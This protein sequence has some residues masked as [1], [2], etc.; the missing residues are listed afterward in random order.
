M[1]QHQIANDPSQALDINIVGQT[2]HIFAYRIWVKEPGAADWTEIA[3][4]DTADSVPDHHLTGPHPDGTLISIAYAVGGK[5]K[6]NF[7][8]LSTFSQGGAMVTGGAV[9]E[10][11][12]T[13]ASG[14][15]AR[16]SR[17][18]LA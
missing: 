8:V 2:P 11:G 1:A 13:S 7:R 10:S 5:P 14:G 15:G 12:Q 9:T 18:T 4:G 3:V 17:I 16:I 6:S